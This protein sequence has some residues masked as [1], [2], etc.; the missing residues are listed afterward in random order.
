MPEPGLPTEIQTYL[1]ALTGTL[2][3]LLG[4]N[5]LG[6]YLFGSA[7]Q[8]AYEP[9]LSDLD[10]QAVTRH[11]LSLTLRQTIAAR[12]SHAA[13]PCPAHGLELVL[14]P[15]G[16]VD[17]M[18]ATPTFDLNLNTGGHRTQHAGYDPSHEEAHWFVLDI[19]LG[20][21]RGQALW[22]PPPDALF[23][24]VP[25]LVVLNALAQSQTWHALHD[26]AAPNRILNAARTWRFLDTGEWGSK[27]EG[28]AWAA[29]QTRRFPVIAQAW[30]VR[31][32]SGT[33]DPADVSAFMTFLDG[34]LAGTIS[35]GRRGDPTSGGL[36]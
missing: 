9:G 11:P 28:V 5:L 24:E 16:A 22:G 29:Q 4:E 13:L 14:Y 2:R 18:T 7:A 8:G 30:L 21:E 3:A 25:R 27:P 23:A 31:R 19:A 34:R 20:R 12:L 6:V 17:P 36:Q 35:E 26:T 32:G 33:L 10:V 15:Q 1:A